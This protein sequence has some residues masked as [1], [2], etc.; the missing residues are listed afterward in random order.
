MHHVCASKTTA[1]QRKYDFQ[2]SS[3]TSSVFR[4]MLRI[5]GDTGKMAPHRASFLRARDT[6]FWHKNFQCVL[7]RFPVSISH[8][9][10]ISSM[11]FRKT[12]SYSS[13]AIFEPKKQKRL[14]ITKNN[15]A[16]L[17]F[18]TAQ[19]GSMSPRHFLR[20]SYTRQCPGDT[21]MPTCYALAC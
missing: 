4:Q 9:K 20:R 3:Q 11:F 8:G 5:R 13:W 14:A 21:F 6:Y 2:C 18:V 10:R 17:H 1:F 19:K 16:A 7:W 12:F 15:A